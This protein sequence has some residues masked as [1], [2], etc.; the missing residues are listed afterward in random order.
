MGC[1]CWLGGYA[2]GEPEKLEFEG[3][4]VSDLLDFLGSKV[5]SIYIE[6]RFEGS[7]YKCFVNRKKSRKYFRVYY[8]TYKAK[9]RR[10]ESK[11]EKKPLSEWDKEIEDIKRFNLQGFWGGE[12]FFWQICFKC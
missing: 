1:Y 5:V 2:S 10:W 4:R 8:K 6:I 11:V 3:S 9:L 7:I 12:L